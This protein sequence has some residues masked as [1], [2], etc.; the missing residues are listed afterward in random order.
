MAKKCKQ[1]KQCPDICGK[2]VCTLDS[3]LSVMRENLADCDPDSYTW[4]DEHLKM[5]IQMAVQQVVAANKEEFVR[6]KKVRLENGLCLQSVC[7]ECE[8][9]VEVVSN[10]GECSD[11]PKVNAN[12]LDKWIS[13]HYGTTC[14]PKDAPY[15]ITDLQII[16]DAGC[17]FK[18]TPP[19]PR[20]GDYYLM[21]SCVE[22]PCLLGDVPDSICRHWTEVFFL[23][24]SI[25]YMLEDDRST[26]GKAQIWFDWFM[27]LAKFEREVDRDVF[28]KS[29]KFGTRIDP[30]ID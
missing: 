8:G 18:V 9:I 21:L 27:Q 20:R 15:E 28:I 13:R 12:K 17:Q 4:S 30:N 23:A 19:V 10:V 22:Y 6:T 24:M 26:E 2:L 11:P 25:V 3:L 14:L 7:K 1:Q 5:A 16:G 29:I